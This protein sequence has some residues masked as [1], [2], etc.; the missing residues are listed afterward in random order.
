[1]LPGFPPVIF[2]RSL[3]IETVQSLPAMTGNSA[4]SGHVASA[5]SNEVGNNPYEVF[6]QIT[7]DASLWSATG[8]TNQWVQRQVPTAITVYKYRVWPYGPVLT[9]SPKDFKLQGS[10]DGSSY[11]DLD[12]RAGETGWAAGVY[13]EYD[14]ANPGLYNRYRL[15]VS[16]NNGFGVVTLQEL[17]LLQAIP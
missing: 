7:D 9:G 13:R 3:V 15:F 4:P 6:D 11:I 16:A 1:M 14:V 17:E 8:P 2:K 10:N 5:S 12:T